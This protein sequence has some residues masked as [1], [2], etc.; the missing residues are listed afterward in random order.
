MKMHSSSE[1]EIAKRLPYDKGVPRINGPTIYGASPGRDFLYLIPVRGERPLRFS[2]KG[3]LP[4]GL[5][6]DP[7]KGIVTGKAQEKGIFGLTV[8][9]ENRLGKTERGFTI[10]IGENRLAR[11]PL[12]GWCSWN[13]YGRA[14]SAERV[15]K[16]AEALVEK[17]LT[18]RGYSYINID[19][20]WQGNRLKGSGL[21][22]NEKFPDMK[23]LVDGIH[24]LGLKAGI[25]STPMVI[26]Y[27]S[28]VSDG[29][30]LRGSTSFPL[31]PVY[32]DYL[33][34]GCGKTHHEKEDAK[35]WA[36]WGFDY[37]KYD[38]P[39][40]DIEHTRLMREALE[41]TN[42]DFIFSITAQCKLK[43]FDE[44]K[45]HANM[46]RSG[47]DTYDL[48][49]L[50]YENAFAVEEWQEKTQPGCWYDMD[51]LALG[52]MTCWKHCPE[53]TD[54]FKNALPGENRL[55]R[56]EMVAHM[57]MWALF[58]SPIQISCLLDDI[59]DFTL[60]LLSNEE[61][62]DINQ[63]SLGQ[64]VSCIG[65]TLGQ[66]TPDG[67]YDLHTRIYARPLA[68]GSV[69]AGFFNLGKGAVTITLPLHAKTRIR[70]PWA[71]KDLGTFD[72]NF[73]VNV[74]EHGGRIFRLYGM[75][76]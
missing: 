14:V 39:H 22:A 15:M 67:A 2:L 40:C 58:P 19:S 46:L 3:G 64:G 17:G 51:M 76:K 44:Y 37:L 54:A 73:T 47:N 24:A 59:D 23:A 36:E 9:V 8:C 60:D 30:L 48:W 65:K 43:W 10:I 27:G 6:L 62:L 69:A 33:W 34:G 1:I 31:D 70:D 45:K 50:L 12:L 68:D 4:S 16:T 49:R 61:I 41:E 42:R 71:L 28:P 26:A 32:N 25:Y 66:R 52:K 13:A 63:D 38:W 7:S 53:F 57:S 35:L 72:C 11:T 20:C 21:Q 29:P 56:H 74:P 55:T 18:A 75:E 5:S